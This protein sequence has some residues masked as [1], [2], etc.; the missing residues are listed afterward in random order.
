MLVKTIRDKFNDEFQFQ[1]FLTLNSE[2][3]QFWTSESIFCCPQTDFNDWTI[4]CYNE[5]QRGNKIIVLVIPVN[6][7]SKIF[8]KY[9]YN[10]ADIEFYE[11]AGIYPDNKKII[12]PLMAIIYKKKIIQPKSFI[13]DFNI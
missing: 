4:K 12:K 10:Q 2:L 1:E 8:H 7:G 13:L 3:H 5:W 6:T 11:G 9:I